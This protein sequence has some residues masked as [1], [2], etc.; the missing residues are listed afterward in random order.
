MT[1]RLRHAAGLF[2]V[3]LLLFCPTLVSAQDPVEAA[4]QLHKVLVDN[5]KVRVYEVTLKPGDK[6]P[7]HSHPVHVVYFITGGKARFG[8]PDG[9]SEVRESPAGGAV[10]NDP[11]THTSENT[12]GD[13]T[14]V[15]IVE[16]KK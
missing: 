16:L 9:K 13:V 10:W 2:V 14:R 11:V 12:G 4:P 8:L 3:P 6:I 1:R 5:D 7:M 15:V